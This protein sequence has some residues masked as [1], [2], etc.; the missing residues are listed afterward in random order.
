MAEHLAPYKQLE[1]REEAHRR[2]PSSHKNLQFDDFGRFLNNF[3][4]SGGFLTQ[5]QKL[6]KNTVLKSEN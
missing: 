2:T 4:N 1:V 3:C 6:P 5:N